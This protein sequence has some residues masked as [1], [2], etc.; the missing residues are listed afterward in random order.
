MSENEGIY[1]T[2]AT[3]PNN[4]KQIGLYHIISGTVQGRDKWSVRLDVPDNSI[5]ITRSNDLGKRQPYYFHYTKK[6][7][8]PVH[9]LIYFGIEHQNKI[10]DNRPVEE[11]AYDLAE[12]IKSKIEEK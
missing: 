10:D 3:K 6:W 12:K 4:E 5:D 8:K 11:Q 2:H 7:K 9:N 1:I